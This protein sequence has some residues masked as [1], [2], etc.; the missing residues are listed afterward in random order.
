MLAGSEA[1]EKTMVKKDEPTFDES[2]IEEARATDEKAEEVDQTTPNQEPRS[3]SGGSI[4]DDIDKLRQRQDFDALVST[5][6]VL[7]S[8]PVGK[9]GK[10]TWFRVLPGEEWQL[11]AAL[12]KLEEDGT[13]FYIAPDIYP[14]LEAEAIRVVLRTVV[15]TQGTTSLWP[16]RFP[17]ADGRDSSWWIS[18][19]AVAL[20]A[21]T[22]WV[23][24]RAN[25]EAGAYDVIKATDN[26]GEPDL[27]QHNFSELLEIAFAGKVIERL[28]HP[29]VLRLLGRPQ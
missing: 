26:Y 21:E 14:D 16:I 3:T 9:P 27:P 8:V 24:M 12:L 28:D 29:V 2:K 13:Y 19:R 20:Q 5:Q 25:M 10:Q 6:R 1:M 18:A 23:R 11:T 17:S 15:T 7:V 4:F 22:E